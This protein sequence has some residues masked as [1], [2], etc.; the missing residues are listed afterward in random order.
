MDDEGEV[1]LAEVAYD[2]YAANV[3]ERLEQVDV[4]E[5]DWLWLG[6][7]NRP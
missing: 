5:G 2:K 7:G 6:C 4:Q 3:I 1:L